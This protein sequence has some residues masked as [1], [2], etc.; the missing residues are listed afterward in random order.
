MKCWEFTEDIVWGK[1]RIEDEQSSENLTFCKH[2]IRLMILLKMNKVS[3]GE[4]VGG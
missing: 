4:H 2:D 3:F 1:H